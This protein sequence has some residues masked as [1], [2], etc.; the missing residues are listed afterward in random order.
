MFRRGDQYRDETGKVIGQM[1]SEVFEH[2]GLPTIGVESGK[3]HVK[4]RYDKIHSACS[5]RNEDGVYK[6]RISRVCEN[7]INELD[8][9]VHD[10]IDP[11]VLKGS[12]HAID[13]YGHFL[14]YYSDDI[15]PL[16]FESLTKDN[17]SYLQIL[18]DEDERKLEEEEE[19]ELAI[20]VDS[21]Y[22]VC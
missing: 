14:M 17:R 18:M 21:Y 11:E 15:E 3:G 13:S 20:Q 7:L 12:D 16:G 2:Y 1:K 5:L 9:A 4:D 19:D 6:F 8:H 22:D 10:D